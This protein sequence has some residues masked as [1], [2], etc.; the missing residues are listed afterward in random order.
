MIKRFCS[1]AWICAK[2]KQSG[3][4]IIEF[5][6]Y[7]L[8]ISVLTLVFY[9]LI[10][11]YVTSQ[12]DLTRWVI[13]NSFTLCVYECVFGIG[14][15]FDEERYYGRLRLIIVSPTSKLTVI[16]YSGIYSMLVASITII[17]AL[18]FGGLIFNIQFSSLNINMI[19][20]SIFSAAFSC[21]GLGFVLSVFALIT[22]SM[23][24][25]LNLTGLLLMIYS[26][27]NFP[28]SQLPYFFQLFSNV[29]P[30]YRSITAANLSFS[31]NIDSHYLGLICGEL[32]LG[33]AYLITAFILIRHIEHIAIRKATLEVF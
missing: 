11:K 8:I 5:L 28:I 32:L 15:S 31:G 1:Q 2:V 18:L 13:G 14:G 25:M 22:D 6:V 20:I 24:L 16:M 12:V 27:A 4:D 26:G 3:I 33:V 21:V 7:R 30:L 19:M 9:C 29:F 10:A 17:L 23:Y